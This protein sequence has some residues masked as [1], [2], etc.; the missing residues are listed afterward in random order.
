MVMWFSEIYRLS[1][2]LMKNACPPMSE[3]T[4][5]FIRVI[6]FMYPLLQGA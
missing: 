6:S 2:L 3:F 5:D 1:V 4:E